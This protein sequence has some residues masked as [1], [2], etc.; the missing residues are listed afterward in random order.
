M[1][2]ETPE[3]AGLLAREQA[4]RRETEILRDANFALTKDLS[5]ER[6]VET[7]LDFLSLLVP[8]DSANVMLRNG[9]SQFVVSALRRYEAFQDVETARFI[10]LDANTNPIL[11]R[12]CS[13][14]QTDRKS[15]RLNSSH[16]Q[17]S[18]AVFSLKK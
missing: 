9:D 11:Q 10:A 7:L 17:I 16:D 6:V 5:L 18:Y 2:S 15:T 13:T 1:N 4:I 14:K 12:I 8:Y 3:L